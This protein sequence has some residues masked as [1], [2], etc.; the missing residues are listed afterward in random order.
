MDFTSW[1]TTLT[2]AI[3]AVAGFV[4]FSPELFAD[5]PIVVQLSKYI[6]AGGMIAFGIVSRDNKV[7]DEQAAAGKKT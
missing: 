6:G 4:L 7:S 3:T 2:A 5:Y 1:K